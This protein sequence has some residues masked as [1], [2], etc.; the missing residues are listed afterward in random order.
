MIQFWAAFWRFYTFWSTRDHDEDVD[1]DADVENETE[2][3]G[4]KKKTK[5]KHGNGML[6]VSK[7]PFQS[8]CNVC[9]LILISISHFSVIEEKSETDVEAPKKPTFDD[10]LV[11]GVY[12]HRSDRLKNNLLISHPMVKIHVVDEITGQYVKKEDWWGWT[13]TLLQFTF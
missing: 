8:Q 11:L 9:W 10:S 7:A 1:Q 12:V 4:K 3:K 6:A 5:K 2:F 13:P